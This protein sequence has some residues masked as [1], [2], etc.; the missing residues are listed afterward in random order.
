ME[1][2][3]QDVQAILAKHEVL[4]QT[5]AAQNKKILRQLF[6][7]S[8]MGYVKIALIL[9]PLILV[10]IFVVPLLKTTIEYYT[11]MIGGG[12]TGSIDSASIRELLKEFNR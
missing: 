4:L 2:V 6:W 10:F 12:A 8:V 5:I 3:T 1:N 11:S 9:V 7:S